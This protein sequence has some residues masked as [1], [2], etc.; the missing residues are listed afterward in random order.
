MLKMYI[1][2]TLSQILFQDHS[3]RV[4]DD[5]DGPHVRAEADGVVVEDLWCGVGRLGLDDL[6]P[7]VGIE[8]DGQAKVDDLERV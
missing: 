6:R 5:T 3:Q 4:D 2:V 1:S 7:L 8:L